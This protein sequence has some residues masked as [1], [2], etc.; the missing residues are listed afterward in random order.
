MLNHLT[1]IDATGELGALAGYMLAQLGAAVTRL[2]PAGGETTDPVWNRDK[3]CVAPNDADLP[4]LLSKADILLR[5]GPLPGVD[6]ADYPRLIDVLLTPFACTD[7]PA[8]DMTLMAR[9]GLLHIGGDPDREP[10]RLP[11]QQAYAL[12]AIQ[13][14]IGALTA[15]RARKDKG[16]G[17]I[18]SAY[19]SAVLANYREPVMWDWAGKVGGRQGNLLVRGKSGVNQVWQVADG[20]V[21]WALVDNPGMM[22]AMVALMQADGMAGALTG[23]DWENILVADLPQETLKDWEKLVGA[24]F[25]TKTRAFLA[26]QSN[27]HGMGLSAIDEPQDVLNSAH[28]AAR[29]A[30]VPFNDPASGRTIRVPGPLF[31]SNREDAR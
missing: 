4:A 20:W 17:V 5:N 28:H 10:L 25:A 3:R 19:Q 11:G 18:V 21:T 1:I 2:V 12:G 23:V 13:A 31:R 9:S 16:Q 29:G 7:R 24:F 8:T 14:I 22:R 15:L 27:R 26:E 30:F 6:I